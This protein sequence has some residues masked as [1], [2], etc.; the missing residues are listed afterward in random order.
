MKF[1]QRVHKVCAEF[2]KTLHAETK[3]P[4]LMEKL[5]PLSEKLADVASSLDQ[6]KHNLVVQVILTLTQTPQYLLFTS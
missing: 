6:V 4:L 5:Q 2:L 3:L 1:E